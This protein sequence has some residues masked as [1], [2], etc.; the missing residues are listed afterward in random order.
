MPIFERM[1]VLSET[2]FTT[3][4]SEFKRGGDYIAFM[5]EFK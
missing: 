3:S 2:V 5:S 1:I 4:W